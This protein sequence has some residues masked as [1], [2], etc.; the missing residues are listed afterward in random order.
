LPNID[1]Q[2]LEACGRL[3]PP[4]F[5]FSNHGIFKL[6]VH[7]SLERLVGFAIESGRMKEVLAALLDLSHAIGH[8]DRQMALLGEGNTSARLSLSQFAV[9]ASGCSLAKLTETDLTACS[10]EKVL[11]LLENK[12]L[13]DAEIDQALLDSRI[14]PAA[15]KP[16]VEAMFHAW[17]LTLDGVKFVG[18][19]HP[20]SANQILCSPRARDFAE[21]RIFPDEIV[22]CGPAS[23]FV[24]Y[25]D[26][27][28]VLAREIRE[29]TKVFMQQHGSAPR[30]IVLQN[31]GLIALGSSASAVLGCLQMASKA[32]AIFMGAA[33]LGGPN[34]LTPQQVE[35]IASRAD[36]AY[37]QR[38]LKL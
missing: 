20:V 26:P 15:K 35:R 5:V 3:R 36:E 16:S 8:E 10:F 38:Q 18:H 17:L 24:P 9:K 29:R 25:C 14:D 21:R 34:F 13:S 27:G 32:A 30:L 6:D 37:R 31:H 7:L 22:C 19:C 23:V 2:S 33:A 1:R 28:L 11:A 12:S 4:L